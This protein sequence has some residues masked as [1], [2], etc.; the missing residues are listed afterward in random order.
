[1][2]GMITGGLFNAVAFAGAGFLFSKLNHTGYSEE[3]NR[4][5]LAMEK[6]TRDKEA[7]YEK[8]VGRKDRIDEKRQQLAYANADIDSTNKALD[9]LHT[10]LEDQIYELKLRSTPEPK[11]TNY[12]KPSKE[13]EGYMLLFTS[14]V[15]L[16]VGFVGYKIYKRTWDNA[17]QSKQM[18]SPKN[19]STKLRKVI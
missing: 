6:L 3:A 11:L 18:N 2:T 15:G 9:N 16:G 10:L 7:W 19:S 17:L 14:A 5:N 1:M 12:Y 13:M 4:H 8:E